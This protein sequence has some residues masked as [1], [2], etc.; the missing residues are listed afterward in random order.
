MVLATWQ[1]LNCQ[2]SGWKP[3]EAFA[4]ITRVTCFLHLLPASD[5]LYLLLFAMHEEN[6]EEQCKNLTAVIVFVMSRK[7]R[8]WIKSVT[9]LNAVRC[10]ASSTLPCSWGLAACNQGQLQNG[11]AVSLS[12]QTVGKELR[13]HYGG[14]YLL[15]CELHSGLGPCSCLSLER[16]VFYACFC[17][18]A[19]IPKLS[20]QN[21]RQ[22]KHC[23]T[24]LS[25]CF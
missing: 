23:P 22:L 7:N 6:D 10:S 1:S 19:L 8:W 13:D 4:G 15:P 11:A 17:L 18:S 14:L 9:A 21:R 2:I 24:D 3:C 20:S 5:N 12:G 16:S 25:T